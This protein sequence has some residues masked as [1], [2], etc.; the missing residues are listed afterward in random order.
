MFKDHFDGYPSLG[1][2]DDG[3]VFYNVGVK[4][5]FEIHKDQ[6]FSTKSERKAAIVDRL[7]RTLKTTMW[8]D[9]YSKGTNKWIDVVGDCIHVFA[10]YFT[11]QQIIRRFTCSFIKP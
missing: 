6:Y 3:K 8:K 10:Q 11:I 1:Q 4:S 2:F 9:F 5:L 7:N